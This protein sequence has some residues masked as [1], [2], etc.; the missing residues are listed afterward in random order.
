MEEKLTSKKQTANLVDREKLTLSGVQE[1]FSFDEVLIELDTNQGYLT[2][3]GNDLHI[4]KMNVDEGD[5]VIEG[6]I[7]SLEYHDSQ[8]G[9]KK[10]SLMSKLFK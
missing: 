10:G 9:K 7:D 8:K 6:H 1:I 2:I 5:M 4:L 3:T